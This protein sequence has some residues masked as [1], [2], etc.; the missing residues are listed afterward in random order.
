MTHQ[1]DR[2]RFGRNVF[3]AAGGLVMAHALPGMAAEPVPAGAVLR[4]GDQKGGSRALMDA[5]GVLKDLP[6]KIDWSIF[7]SAS[8]LLEALNADAID[9]GAVGD[10]PF[11][12]AYGG[13]A[14]IRIVL[15]LSTG[16]EVGVPGSAI[17]VKSGSPI[18]APPDLVGKKIATIR[19]SSGHRFLIQALDHYGIKLSDIKLIFLNPSDAKAALEGGSIDAWSIWEPYVSLAELQDGSKAVIDGSQVP[20][21]DYGFNV[22]SKKSI[23]RNHAALSDFLSR[24]I[25]AHGWARNN[26]D[27]FAE[28]WAHETGLPLEVARRARAGLLSILHPVQLDDGVA[29]ALGKIADDYRRAGVPI[30]K[31]DLAAA[32]DPS[33]NAILTQ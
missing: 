14:P 26:I 5:A 30:D 12:F 23:A 10:A 4:V 1:I 3:A 20:R 2:R 7:A 29:Q 18:Q 27:A 21:I 6:Y 31:L 19:G 32:Y 15:A 13:G 16:S 8:T 11:L 28:V 22:A 33:F 24:L 25:V 17:L 9:T